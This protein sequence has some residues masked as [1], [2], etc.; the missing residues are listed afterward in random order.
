MPSLRSFGQENFGFNQNG[1]IQRFSRPNSIRKNGFL[2]YL[3]LPNDQRSQTKSKNEKFNYLIKRDFDSFETSLSPPDYEQNAIFR[4]QN[5]YPSYN[6]GFIRKSNQNRFRFTKPHRKEL[7]K[8]PESR[9][10]NQ[11]TIPSPTFPR[12]NQPIEQVNE[13]RN[14]N[15]E[16]IFKKSH[17]SQSP[18]S[19][20]ETHQIRI[21]QIPQRRLSF[22]IAENYSR[23]EPFSRA[24]ISIHINQ[25]KKHLH[26]N[27]LLICPLDLNG[28]RQFFRAVF[29]FETSKIMKFSEMKSLE[30]QILKHI[31]KVKRY[32]DKPELL[33][34]FDNRHNFRKRNLFYRMH[35]IKRKEENLKFSF[36]ILHKFLRND[37][38]EN[39]LAT[40][41]R[42]PG[43]L[44]QRHEMTLF[45]LFYFSQPI[46][47]M[48]F[49]N[50][51]KH[52]QSLSRFKCNIFKKMS[53]Y[54]FPDNNNRNQ[55]S[56]FR[57]YS[58]K[59]FSS[60]AQSSF[61]IKKLNRLLILGFF[62]FSLWRR[63]LG[64]RSF[65]KDQTFAEGCI[66]KKLIFLVADQN[67]KE[68][69]KMI[70]EWEN[71]GEKQTQNF[72][73]KMKFLRNQG[74]PFNPNLFG[75]PRLEAKILEKIK[76]NIEKP[77]FKFLWSLSEI[78]NAFLDAILSLNELAYPVKH[79]LKQKKTSI[80]K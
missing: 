26:E 53:K 8:L 43:N 16:N 45:Y 31:F 56:K 58:K 62:T 39:E 76:E 59:F 28:A 5:G 2:P 54:I 46:L 73:Q 34:A 78:K 71:I 61:L 52:F 41:V 72:K 10:K 69:F 37:F 44:S 27:Q 23:F 67:D 55:T 70:S 36:R 7:K 74:A 22:K 18:S 68:L 24:W 63:Y 3:R 65:S 42:N 30:A 32:E 29:T 11:V 9:S 21:T 12:P 79:K 80:H 15:F 4:F 25:Q 38:V 6:R 75:K 60:I 50:S 77:N 48:D 49:K 66:Q 1:Y 51:V 33:Q 19:N 47:Q 14:T 17:Q 40:V 57:S 20:L 64:E 35:R 13:A